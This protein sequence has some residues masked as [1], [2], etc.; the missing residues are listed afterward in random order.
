MYGFF[1]TNGKLTANP[2]AAIRQKRLPEK[3]LIYLTNEEQN[4]LLNVV[5]S[6]ENLS[7]KAAAHHERFILRDSAMILLL[8]DTGLR[9]SEMLSTDIADY[10]FVKCQVLVVRKGGDKDIVSYSDECAAY[11]DDYFE[12][13]KA[14]VNDYSGNLPAFTTLNGERLGVR[15]VENL[16]KKYAIASL[17]N[18]KGKTI[19][20]H[21]LR[22]SFAMSFYEASDKDILLLKEKLHHTR[23]NTTNIYAKAAPGKK[24]ETR[25]ILQGL[26]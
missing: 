21:K 19:T 16:V 24:A 9:V 1:M 11:L 26:R 7:G 20:P 3:A 25:N 23:I 2:A 8:L 22:S 12:D 13:Q 6:G 10:D 14:R 17:G 15:A 5:R 4:K 18:S